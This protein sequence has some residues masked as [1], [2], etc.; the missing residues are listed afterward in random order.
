MARTSLVP[1]ASGALGT[2][3]KSAFHQK[4][5]E[6]KNKTKNH[7]QVGFF[8]MV[9]VFKIPE[10][11]DSSPQAP[12]STGFSRHKYWSGLPFLS[13]RGEDSEGQISPIKYQAGL[14]AQGWI[15]CKNEVTRSQ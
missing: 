8:S 13:P 1:Q 15:L 14:V 6:K 9:V 7:D 2:K 10:A 12:L 4:G 5:L 11:L 3:N